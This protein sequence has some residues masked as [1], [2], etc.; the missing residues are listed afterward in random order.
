[1]GWYDKTCPLGK[2]VV[3]RLRVVAE[4][5]PEHVRDL[6]PL[7][8]NKHWCGI[9]ATDHGDASTP[10]NGMLAWHAIYTWMQRGRI[11]RLHYPLRT[12]GRVVVIVVEAGGEAQAD[13]ARHDRGH[14]VLA[15][16][17]RCP[18]RTTTASLST[19]ASWRRIILASLASTSIGAT[20]SGWGNTH[21]VGLQQQKGCNGR[22][23]RCFACGP[24]RGRRRASPRG[25]R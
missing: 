17:L 8:A 15:E 10:G 3:T 19:R 7:P 23:G 4:R 16:D 11:T 22:R 18:N 25:V 21:G 24:P 1:M 5:D 6:Q 20:L 9:N 13:A 2:G 12:L 14:E